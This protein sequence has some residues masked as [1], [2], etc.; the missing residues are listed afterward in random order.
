MDSMF[1]AVSCPPCPENAN[2][3]NGT[4]VCKD[5]FE[6]VSLWYSRSAQK[7]EGKEEV[8]IHLGI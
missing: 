2:C 1:L 7:C 5:G 3:L 6:S 8:R 4:C